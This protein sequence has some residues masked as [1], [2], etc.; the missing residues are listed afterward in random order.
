MHDLVFFF[1]L[2]PND[3][4]FRFFRDHSILFCAVWRL[5]ESRVSF[6]Q[7]LGGFRDVE[8]SV[9]LMNSLNQIEF[10]V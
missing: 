6:N 5:S 10:S 1:F 4:L 3:N 9:P 7:G 8:L 2:F